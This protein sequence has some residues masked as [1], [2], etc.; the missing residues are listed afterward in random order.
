MV[1][2]AAERD[3]HLG[4][5]LHLAADA[6]LAWLVHG[7]QQWHRD[8]L[9][10]PASVTE[11]TDTYRGESDALGRFLAERCLLAPAFHVFSAELFAAWGKWCAEEGEAVGSNKAFTTALVNRGFG[12]PTP[13]NRGK[14]WQGIGV[15]A[16]DEGGDGS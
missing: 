11:A 16:D 13:T 3:E 6:V 14:R 2:P 5:R 1:V 15:A 9:A 10:E 8:G 4:E 7:H 12:P